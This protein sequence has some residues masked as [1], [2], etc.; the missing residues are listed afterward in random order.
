[1]SLTTLKR[2]L[3]QSEG[4]TGY[5][6]VISLLL[7]G[8]ADHS[9]CASSV[10][11]KAFRQ[12]METVRAT[13]DSDCG[14]EQLFV[15]AGATIQALDSY[16]ARTSHLLK[17]QADEMQNMISMLAQTVISISGGSEL[18]TEALLHIKHEL[19]QAAALEDVE[20]LK[21]RLGECLKT[22]CDETTRQKRDT[23]AIVIELQRNV[24]RVQSSTGP[25][26]DIDPVTALPRAS[27]AKA[28]FAEGLNSIGRKYIVMMVV[29]RLQLINARFGGAVGDQ[30]IRTLQKYV[31][32]NVV[33]H[34]DLLFRWTGPALVALIARQESIDQVRSSL[35]RLLDKRIENEF[36]VG[37]RLALIPL[38]VAWSVIALIPPAA[39]LP[40]YIDK[41]VAAQLPRDYC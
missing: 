24:Q 29:D 5:R 25:N 33:A 11:L 28:A 13:A 3:T 6:K 40:S 2:Y 38:T 10:E 30:V 18:S 22:V 34:G 26:S 7:K 36:D 17:R 39:N 32:S 15:A 21:L 31:E 8:I 14:I 19:E 41:F 12:E 1:M 37:G 35:K 16:N 27:S 9:V 20:K 4:E 23:E